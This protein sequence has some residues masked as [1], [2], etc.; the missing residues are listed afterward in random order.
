MNTGKQ[1]RA[2]VKITDLSPES[3]TSMFDVI[4]KKALGE[5]VDKVKSLLNVPKGQPVSL[6]H[7]LQLVANNKLEIELTVKYVPKQYKVDFLE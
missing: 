6:K 2:Y 3:C 7:L 5:D 4:S 1:T